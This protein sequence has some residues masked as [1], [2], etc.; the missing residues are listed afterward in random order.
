MERF[1]P[2][3]IGIGAQKCAS[4]WIYQVLS[5]HP[6]IFVSTPKELDFFSSFFD[7]G[8][9]WYQ[10]AFAESDTGRLC[11][12]IS[13][14]YFVDSDAPARA[15]AYNP[16]FK[17]VLALRDPIERAYSNH[18]H[19][20]RLLH[21]QGEL[22]FEAGLRNNPMYLEQCRYASHLKRWLEFFPM[23]QIHVVLQ[24]DVKRSPDLEAK[25]LYRFLGV[26]EEHKSEFSLQKANESYMPKSRKREAIYKKISKWLNRVGLSKFS[27]FIRRSAAFQN[28]KSRNRLDIREIV[29]PI[30]DDVMRSLAA[31]LKNEVDELC[32]L[33]GR[34][35][36][37]WPSYKSSIE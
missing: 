27:G 10:R 8:Y 21:L 11:G 13:P 31:E 22:S 12:E 14:S 1:K 2:A 19:D 35:S 33:L 6:E 28:L 18:L 16:D 29:P 3:F 7:R 37:P 4:T 36:F 24:E 34:E 32:S 20:V 26:C 25:K 17:I 30:S 5:D 23:S 9:Q 15:K